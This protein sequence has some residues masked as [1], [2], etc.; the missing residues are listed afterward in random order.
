MA[1]RGAVLRGAQSI[2][3]GAR[4][5]PAPQGSGAGYNNGRGLNAPSI[6]A[7][8]PLAAQLANEGGYSR[9]YG[10]FLP[11]PTQAFTEG[12]FGPFSPI[13]PVPI[14][15]PPD[16]LERPEARRWQYPVGWNLPTGRPGDEGLKL[17]SFEQ[18]R[19]LADAYSVAR[20]AIEFRKNQV[21][22]IEWD[23]IPT[24]DAA[25]AYQNN[26]A[27]MA[28]FGKRQAKAKKFF[29]QPDRDYLSYST[30]IGAV[31]EDVFVY[32][33]LS[34]L[35]RP[36]RVR[37]KGV[38][39]GNMDSLMTITGST[40]RPLVDLHG[41]TPRP[42]GP[43]FQ[44]FL[45]GVPRSDY[46][47][48]ITGADLEEADL[49]GTQ[50][51]QFR[52]D[53]LIYAPMV[54][55]S[56]SPYGFSPVER[57]L[58]PIQTGIQ[59][60][61]YQYDFFEEG[62]VPAAY[63]IPGD[64][65]T[66][67]NQLREIQDA[68]NAIAGD[69]AYKQKIVVLPP[70][71]KVEPMRPVI[72]ADALDQLVME[73]V[74]M[75]FAV[76]PMELGISPRASTTTSPG[77]ANQMAKAAQNASQDSGLTPILK[78]LQDIF[79]S[80]LVN[81]CNQTDMQFTFEGLQQE[82]D[83]DAVTSTLVQQFTNGM[84]TL[85]ECRQELNLQP[86]GLEE[87]SE[88][89]ITTPNG[90]VP[91][92]TAVQGAQ[93][94]VAQAQAQ[95]AQTQA[96]AGQ[97]AAQTENTQANTASTAARSQMAQESHEVSMNTPPDPPPGMPGGAK[98]AP[99]SSAGA[100]GRAEAAQ[101]TASKP[102]PGH[103]AAVA[104]NNAA[105]SRKKS[106]D[107]D[108]IITKVGPHGYSHG[109]VKVDANPVFY[110]GTTKRFKPGDLIQPASKVP[111][112]DRVTGNY[113]ESSPDHVYMTRDP[114]QAAVYAGMRDDPQPEST[115]DDRYGVYQVEPT[116]QFE[117]DPQHS[118]KVEGYY[119]EPD[120]RSALPLRVVKRL[121]Y[122]HEQIRDAATPEPWDE[123]DPRLGQD[124]SHPLY[125]GTIATQKR[126]AAE[127]EALTRHLVKGRHITTWEPRFISQG[128]LASIAKW[129]ADGVEPSDAVSRATVT[130]V[131]LP[132][133]EYA[134]QDGADDAIK[135]GGA[136]FQGVE[137]AELVKVGPKGYVHGWIKVDPGDIEAHDYEG[138]VGNKSHITRTESGHMP[139]A[140]IAN[141]KGAAGEYPGQ[142]RNRAGKDWE[143]FKK[144]I[145]ANGIKD[146]IFITVDRGEEPKISEGS[147]R[148][149]A[150]VELGLS[151]V[152]VE[153]KYFGHAEQQ[154]TIVQRA[155]LQQ[156]MDDWAGLGGRRKTMVKPVDVM[157]ALKGQSDNESASILASE[158]KN[159]SK[160]AKEVMYRG[161]AVK[162]GSQ[163]ARKLL[164]AAKKGVIDLGPSSF[165]D[166][167]DIAHDFMGDAYRGS[168]KIGIQVNVRKMTGIP[169]K[170]SASSVELGGYTESEWL[171]GG[172]YKVTGMTGPLPA[173]D[174]FS[175]GGYVINAEQSQ[176][177]GD[178]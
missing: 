154:G 148:R 40:I 87:S 121:P 159:N 167:E 27:K 123:D 134:W 151:K 38:L 143:D 97:T 127:L 156:A 78:F 132:P 165:T 44:Q 52:G 56:W 30:W 158:L 50:V 126:A 41:G 45:Y 125:T 109:W 146:P 129:M 61:V 118:G 47:T 175:D 16:G 62:S 178:M 4:P 54:P 107:T 128:T 46:M 11:R 42:P 75:A 31:L 108:G 79:N 144:D 10:P 130:S 111:D 1:S 139:T 173:H 149:D 55:R 60:Q 116:G 13:L 73:Q 69:P 131:A 147:H 59:K 160:P 162:P 49:N 101:N 135:A 88:P 51:A 57:A 2:P 92:S 98:P 103:N 136:P 43:A 24:A 14:D 20:A 63:I 141:L 115:K 64:M 152:P 169:I 23:I 58:I 174:G 163:A 142:H 133:S 33:A 39:G 145:A 110:H 26:P 37:G 138:A 82:E 137:A 168:G 5:T 28:E 8:S 114:G 172:R 112:T 3:G 72:T 67:P 17:A 21:R 153:V 166:D 91:L 170:P 84:R 35:I 99:T 15:A 32:D 102:T 105:A 25:K 164:A 106:E 29:N 65:A 18:L 94:A 76:S 7:V 100:E 77:A 86:Y 9:S 171:S 53:Q 90:P 95:T 66:T 161:I 157:A 34:L 119:Q 70:G 176:G 48:M 96:Q 83:V 155:K 22:G 89:L 177:L 68:L 81:V 122:S 93:N 36:T 80:I 120:Y 12:A 104:A 150:A 85:D 74:T 140:A 19:K 71:S 124:I 113:G 117:K 6:G